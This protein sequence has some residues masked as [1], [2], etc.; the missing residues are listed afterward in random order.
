MF[1]GLYCTLSFLRQNQ[2]PAAG[3]WPH[4]P[5]LGDEGGVKMFPV[6][7]IY[8]SNYLPNT[9]YCIMLLHHY[10]NNI[11]PSIEFFTPSL[12]FPLVGL[13]WPLSGRALQSLYLLLVANPHFLGHFLTS[14]GS[15]DSQYSPSTLKSKLFKT[16][17]I[18]SL[19][20]TK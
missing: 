9:Y 10:M 5:R 4:Q 11:G 2:Y 12:I 15:R 7:V 8:L 13:T 16:Y 18:S 19:D 20:V 6:N 17:F 14:R 3:G 1:I